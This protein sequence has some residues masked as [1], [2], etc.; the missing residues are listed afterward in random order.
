LVN[1]DS[2]FFNKVTDPQA[3]E[4]AK[5]MFPE[6]DN[7]RYTEDIEDVFQDSSIVVLAT[8]WPEF[9]ELDYVK[10]SEIMKNKNF[11]DARNYLDR[12]KMQNIFNFD[13]L[14]N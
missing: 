10:L 6:R 4:E 14:A 11:Y 9:K 8:D 2:Q 3:I 12:D 7:L 5:K 1:V 13:N